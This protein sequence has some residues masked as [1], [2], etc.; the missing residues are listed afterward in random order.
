M[1]EQKSSD[2]LKDNKDI[3]EAKAIAVLPLTA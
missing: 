1:P 2:V 3:K